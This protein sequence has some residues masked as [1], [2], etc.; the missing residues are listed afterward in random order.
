MQWSAECTSENVLSTHLRLDRGHY[1]AQGAFVWT[2]TGAQTTPGSPNFARDHLRNGVLEHMPS[3]HTV[4]LWAGRAAWQMHTPAA[5][6][7]KAVT[8]PVLIGQ[9]DAC[10]GR[11]HLVGHDWTCACFPLRQGTC[12]A[13]S[14]P[15]S[16]PASHA[17]QSYSRTGPLIAYA[18]LDQVDTL[19][20]AS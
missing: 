15:L 14:H 19:C 3:L 16:L 2:Y 4:A 6:T 20:N 7:P 13:T 18:L 11:D 10:G 5:E 12:P 8:L 9:M 17:R 1:G